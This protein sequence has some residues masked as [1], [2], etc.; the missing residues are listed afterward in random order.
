MP[1]TRVT[2]LP[3]ANPDSVGLPSIAVPTESERL[4]VADARLANWLRADAGYSATGWA[5][6]K[7]NKVLA[8]FGSGSMP[9]RATLP[10]YNGKE[11]LQFAS[12]A[13]EIFCAGLL[14]A[15]ADVTVVCFGRAGPTNDT[16][17]LWS[18]GK[19]G[20]QG[21]TYHRHMTAGNVQAV[22]NDVTY[23]ANTA[24]P[25][26]APSANGP[27]VSEWS[28]DQAAKDLFLS[29][30]AKPGTSAGFVK[31]NLNVASNAGTEFHL[32]GSNGAGGIDGGDIGELMICTVPLHLPAHA[33]LRALIW[34]VLHERY[35][36]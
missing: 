29:I 32:G 11:A 17:Y 33:D 1:L 6:R 12:V 3:Y 8:P 27:H 28:L 36:I 24:D 22:I 25:E 2:Q 19:A 5:C 10:A 30:N 31:A 18:N 4:L 20:G 26:L 23:I 7:T 9:N 21:L 15:A 13:N 34:T 16:A 14:P 35:G